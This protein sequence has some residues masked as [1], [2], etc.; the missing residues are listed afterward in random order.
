MPKSRIRGSDMFRVTVRSLCGPSSWPWS[1]SLFILERLPGG[2]NC[3]DTTAP[4]L[5]LF[6]TSGLRHE[7][8]MS[9]IT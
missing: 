2:C 8:T 5:Q 1:H 7:V 3:N 9:I 4:M 6:F